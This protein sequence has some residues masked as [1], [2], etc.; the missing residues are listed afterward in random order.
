M[1]ATGLQM[2]SE[3]NTISS[4]FQNSKVRLGLVLSGQK[5]FTGSLTT[6]PLLGT[7]ST[8]S[9]R[10]QSLYFG[11]QVK[12]R[13]NA[14]QQTYPNLIVCLSKSYYYCSVT[15]RGPPPYLRNGKSYRRPAGV[16]TTRFSRAFQLPAWVKDKVKR[17]LDF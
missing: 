12:R 7:K 14:M 10:R 9:S 1:I 11:R 4:G 15:L 5:S 2:V 6:I 16:K 13:V 17:P 3:E 8:E